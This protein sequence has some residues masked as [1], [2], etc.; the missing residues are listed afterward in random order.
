[1]GATDTMDIRLL[2]QERMQE[3]WQTQQRH[4]E[5]IQDPPGVQQDRTDDQGR[6]HSTRV[7]LCMWLDIPGVVP[8]ALESL[9]ARFVLLK[10]N[11]IVCLC[12]FA[13]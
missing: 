12:V 11:V 3:I 1:M 6:G 8:P 2:D 7:T 13:L 4:I 5:C 10:S 9:R